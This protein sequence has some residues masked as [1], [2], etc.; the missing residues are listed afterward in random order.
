MPRGLLSESHV[1]FTGFPLEGGEACVGESKA[2][3]SKPAKA[4]RFATQTSDELRT[5]LLMRPHTKCGWSE[6]LYSI[7]YH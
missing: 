6:K 3:A 1:S 2:N 7:R 5:P 4:H